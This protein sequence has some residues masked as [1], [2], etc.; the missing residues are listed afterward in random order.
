MIITG[1]DNKS[2]NFKPK[3]NPKQSSSLHVKA[4]NLLR[5]MFKYDAILEE[6]ILPGTK[7]N[8]RNKN[9]IADIYVPNYML[10]V[11]VHGQQHYVF[12][13]H[14]YANKFEFIKA[15][16]RDRD[17]EEWCKLNKFLYLELPYNE[18]ESEWKI[19]IQNVL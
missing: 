7:V 13:K 1:L 15:K 11:E 16:A 12:N 4:V 3:S 10:F 6:V 17:K 19:R 9:L 14:F 5:D 18:S 8:G 2:Y